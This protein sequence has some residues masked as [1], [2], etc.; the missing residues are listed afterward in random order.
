M[1][2]LQELLK[3]S[4]EIK[5]ENNLIYEQY[6]VFEEAINSFKD[7]PN[8]WK[9][10]SSG[11][12]GLADNGYGGENSKVIVLAQKG[13]IKDE[14]AIGNAFRKAL[15]TETIAAVWL[16][17]NDEPMVIA[18]KANGYDKKIALM[19][20][21]GNFEKIYKKI[22]GTS[23]RFR[24]QY[25]PPKYDY[26]RELTLGDAADKVQNI[27]YQFAKSIADPEQTN[28]YDII[29]PKI[30]ELFQTGKLNIVIK[31]LEIDYK[32]SDIRKDRSE[33]KP[34][35][36]GYELPADIKN[37]IEVVKKFTTKK[38]E[39][40]VEKLKSSFNTYINNVL[41]GT[42]D[43]KEFLKYI[44]TDIAFIKIVLDNLNRFK[45]NPDSK[46]Y[47]ERLLK[48]IKELESL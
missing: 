18:H 29:K 15:K 39:N 37:R 13:K 44:E 1:K 33:N 8:K 46:W 3:E 34:L 5:N 30:E 48:T 26:D 23:G 20:A 40:R 21:D 43:T 31:G 38:V 11:Y 19:Q 35:R 22:P 6:E 47:K 7:L 10:P 32:R 16:E 24:G 17:I 27:V 28:N 9:K 36:Q 42:G 41:Y 2:T 45:E 4:I 25:I 14:Q 12:L